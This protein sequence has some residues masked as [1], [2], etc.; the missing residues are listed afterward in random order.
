MWVLIPI[1]IVV[2]IIVI[3]L[4][5]FLVDQ[6]EDKSVHK[7]GGG[8]RIGGSTKVPFFAPQHER[9]G[10][11]GE[12]HVNWHL[13]R[14]LRNDEYLFANL[15]LKP[16]EKNGI[17]P[18]VDCVLLSRKGIFCIET[19][20]WVGHI[21][22]N[23]NDEKWWQIYDSPEMRDRQH[24]NPIKQNQSH[25]IQIKKILQCKHFINNVVILTSFDDFEGT[26]NNQVFNVE[27][28]KHYFNSLPENEISESELVELYKKLIPYASDSEQ[29]EEHRK[30]N[31][32][33]H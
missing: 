16:N 3:I 22:G 7:D 18:E 4:I 14:L 15:L 27:N 13:R 28:F 17:R 6:K 32:Y 31:S 10:M 2:I 19:K 30:L 25:C 8:Q 24:Y 12:N 5:G 9:V 21:R 11:Q 29:L 33:R 23:F 26:T 1:S 20:S